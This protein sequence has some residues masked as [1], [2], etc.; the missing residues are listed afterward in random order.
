MVHDNVAIGG[1]VGFDVLF[2][3]HIGRDDLPLDVTMAAYG[4]LKAEYLFGTEMVRPFV[5]LG[6]GLYTI[7]SHSIDGGPNTA[8]IYTKVG[9][10]L[11]IA[12]QVG[13]DV[14]RVRFAV[15]YNA[16][17]GAGIDVHE[18]VGAMQ[19]TTSVS[20]NYLSLELAFRFGGGRKLEPVGAP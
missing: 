13:V 15:T 9:D 12:P 2:G 3:G 1:R 4:L 7:G 20:Q 8:G 16:I 10:Y 14:G 19:Q 18:T 6:A 5:G 17:V 11:G